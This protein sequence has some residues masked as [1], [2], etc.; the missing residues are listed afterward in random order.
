MKKDRLQKILEIIDIYRIET[1]DELIARLRDCGYEVTQ[2]TV[3]RDIKRLHLIKIQTDDGHS[4]YSLPR[5]NKFDTNEKYRNIL[6]QTIS[7]VHCANNLVVVRTYSGMA[8][9]AGAAI[10]AM[11]SELLLGSIAGDDTIFIVAV[12]N[13]A[14][15]Q[16]VAILK[17]IAEI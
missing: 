7:A 2:A 9:A 3:S 10:D 12:C 16:F 4:K 6:H 11:Q 1:Q 15:S 8:N 13:Q 5:V 17:S 14:A